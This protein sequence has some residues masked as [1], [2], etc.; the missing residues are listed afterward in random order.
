M[1]LKNSNPNGFNFFNKQFTSND[2]IFSK[3]LKTK[4]NEILQSLF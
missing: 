4:L 3:I 1:E 2:F